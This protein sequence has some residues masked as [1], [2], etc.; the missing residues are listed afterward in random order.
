MKPLKQFL[1][2]L[3]AAAAVFL[4]APAKAA[5]GPGT[6]GANMADMQAEAA[7]RI[8]V[9]VARNLGVAVDGKEAY[10]PPSPT[11]APSPT[12]EDSN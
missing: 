2:A 1:P 9:E 5:G 12:P 7:Y 4:I 6:V 10:P 3:I 11:P 8:G